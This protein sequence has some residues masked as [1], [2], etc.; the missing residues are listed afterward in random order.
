MSKNVK[1]DGRECVGI[2]S[3]QAFDV[4]TNEYVSFVDTSDATATADDILKDKTAYVNGEKVIGTGA[5]GGGDQPVMNAPTIS[6]S[7]R[8]LTMTNPSTNGNFFSKFK[9]F[10][11][12]TLKSS[13]T[14]KTID[15]YN[16]FDADGTYNLAAKCSGTNFQDSALS[17]SVSYTKFTPTGGVVWYGNA[18]P[19]SVPRHGLA[20][21][22]VGNY[23]LFGGGE[24]NNYSKIVDA[25]DESLTRIIPTAFPE[26]TCYAS[27]TTVGN[28]ALFREFKKSYAYDTSLTLTILNE[29]QGLYSDASATTVGNYALFGG[30]GS[31]SS[32][33]SAYS[34][35][36]CAYD[37]SLTQTIPTA[38]S[39]ARGKLA[40]T[41]VGNYALFGGGEYVYSSRNVVDAYDTSLTR[42]IPTTLSQARRLLSA[43]TVGNYALFGGGDSS[44]GTNSTY[45]SVVD[46]YDTSLTRTI[47]TALS[48]GRYGLVATTVGNYT[49]FGGG[50]QTDGY[51]SVVD[52]YDPSLTQTIPT[53]L[54][55]TKFFLAATTVGNYALF[56]GGLNS[57]VV[58]VY[59]I[60]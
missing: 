55:S 39:L 40:A 5:G 56:G 52:A 23:A 30:G 6:L 20:A 38:L 28:Y 13:Q 33:S 45:S 8:Q 17:S 1:I 16:Y 32:S 41:T 25:Y 27:A 15:L 21:T 26:G 29:S 44:G 4:D 18:T 35:L 14:E 58:D 22:T 48:K 12:N 11:D 57:D 50:E 10:V 9:V 7:G 51:S 47:A 43:A 3:I 31:N 37:P 36:V 42:T 59:T 54:S 34:S 24:Y 60:Q 49:L 19:L 53:A 2:S 46:A